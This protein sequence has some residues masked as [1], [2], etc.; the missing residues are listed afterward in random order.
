MKDSHETGGYDLLYMVA[1]GR[2]TVGEAKSRS[3]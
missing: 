2:K 1:E 3:K